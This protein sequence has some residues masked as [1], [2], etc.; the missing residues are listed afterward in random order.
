MIFLLLFTRELFE[1]KD[2]F[3]KI[4]IATNIFLL[5]FVFLAIMLSITH[6]PWNNIF[7]LSIIFINLSFVVFSI[8]MYF[9]KHTTALLYLTGIIVYLF[10]TVMLALMAMGI[11]EYS[12]ISRHSLFLGS[13]IEIILFQAA[14]MKR[15]RTIKEIKDKAQNELINLQHKTQQEL[16]LKVKDRTAQIEAYAKEKELL[17][18]E[19]HHRV[20]NNF[21]SL[22]SMLWIDDQ[23]HNSTHNQ[24]LI[25]QLQAISSI[26][27]KLYGS[28]DVN[29]INMKEYLEELIDNA[30]ISSMKNIE[31][32]KDIESIELNFEESIGM[33]IVVN[34][35]LTN[36]IKHNAD[37]KNLILTIEFKK[38]NNKSILKF[39]DNGQGFDINNSRGFGLILIKE[40]IS[41]LQNATYNFNSNNGCHFYLEFKNENK[42]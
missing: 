10:G 7:N 22:I 38:Q 27:E 21:H 35:L 6:R 30:I 9:K 18:K 31:V 40:Y 14:L 5:W 12:E 19:V 8:N 41:E 11:N 32:R 13:L 16:E 29:S 23:N 39:S 33:G 36:A 20:K 25:N 2:N 1:T 42:V 37:S 3:P 4:Y 34:E 26:H 15:Q 17:L 24:K 28:K